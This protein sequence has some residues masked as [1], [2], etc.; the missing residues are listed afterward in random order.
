MN[1]YNRMQVL[2]DWAQYDLC[3]YIAPVKESSS[4][5]PGIYNATANGCKIP[6][7][8]VLM[9][10][11]CVNNCKYC[12]NQA[13]RNF[14]RLELTPKEIA[15]IFLDYYNNSHVNGLFL[16]SGIVKN[17]DET[18][19]N[20]I[21]VVKLLRKDY[22]YDDYIHLKV[23][24][25]ASKD[26]IKRAM[27]LSNRVS[28]NIEAST[29]DGLHEISPNKSYQKDILRR[30]KWINNLGKKNKKLAPSG[31]TTQY[32]IGANDESDEDV[33]K[34]VSNLYK[35]MNLKRSYYSPFEAIAGTELENKENCDR[36]RSN[37]LYQGDALIHD[38][39]FDINELNFDNN[40]ILKKEDPKIAAAKM[41]DIFPVDINSGSFKELIRVPGI[42]LK[43]AKR[44][45]DIRK[46]KPFKS[47]NQLKELGVVTNRAQTYI[48]ISGNYQSTLKL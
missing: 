40:G 37:R 46:N 14:T 41:R 21:E 28:I 17:I 30:F 33:L 44:I 42:G 25:G 26:S 38:Y 1:V 3:D 9:S 35:K 34:S 16:S 27:E 6:L 11:K 22:G 8:K 7:F 5:L 43:S 36:A 19:E 31:V 18:M 48:K 24:P 47:I 32:I 45:I 10:N 39:N 12:I 23:I 13:K 15:K 29:S 20:L 2:C 4:N